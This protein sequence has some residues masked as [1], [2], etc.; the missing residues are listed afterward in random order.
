MSPTEPTEP[1][2]PHAVP[3]PPEPGPSARVRTLVAVGLQYYTQGLVAGLG[4]LVLTSL[5]AVGVAFEDGFV[6]VL[7]AGA[8]PWV[9]KLLWAVALDARTRTRPGRARLWAVGGQLGA[10]GALVALAIGPAPRLLAR[11]P[12]LSAVPAFAGLWFLVN[13]CLAL[14]DAATDAAMLDATRPEDRARAGTTAQVGHYAG[15]GLMTM[16]LFYYLLAQ[17]PVRWSPV[18]LIELAAGITMVLAPAALLFPS[19]EARPALPP[20]GTAARA[21]VR[22]PG[23]WIGVA[24][25]LVAG[26][27][28]PTSSAISQTFLL[29][30]LA[31]P[32]ADFLGY[33]RIAL[34]VG[35]AVLVAWTP[36][37]A[38]FGRATPALVG[39]ALVGATY[40]VYGAMPD[41]WAQPPALIT[42][43][44]CEVAGQGLLFAGLYGL[45]MDLTHPSL[46]AVQFTL[47][48]SLIN[49]GRV[50]G[51]KLAEQLVARSGYGTLYVV[52]GAL[53]LL[54]LPLAWVLGRRAPASFTPG[55]SGHE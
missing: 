43:G 46:R 36:I 24:M 51:P 39:G 52:C 53:F 9:A 18:A 37:G 31:V 33:V 3:G 54:V 13:A 27:P 6:P 5:A 20:V 41:L 38:R 28:G 55:T 44:I 4:G 23:V 8:L 29:Q 10:T 48:M 49:V 15:F 16:G 14:Q 45:L 50:A 30:E 34:V 32:L 35:L 11:A 40:L 42:V 26:L 22:E 17:A 21:L 12:D 1:R 2:P 25:A 7:M 47:W 19:V